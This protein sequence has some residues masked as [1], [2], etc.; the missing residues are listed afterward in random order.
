M[1]KISEKLF[2]A[3]ALGISTR[4]SVEKYVQ[5]LNAIPREKAAGI[6]DEIAKVNPE[7]AKKINKVIEEEKAGITVNDRELKD[8]GVASGDRALAI[9]D[10][11][12]QFKTREEKADYWDDLVSKKIITTKVADQL[13]RLM[14]RVQNNGQR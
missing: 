8:K 12:N 7:L 2:G 5:Q 10:R 14:K 3:S 1:K 6:F 11:F 4:P 13:E 9:A